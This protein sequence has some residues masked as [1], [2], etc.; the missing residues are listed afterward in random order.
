MDDDM[1]TNMTNAAAATAEEKAIMNDI[2]N[3]IDICVSNNLHYDI[4]LVCYKCLKDKHR[5]VSKTSSSSSS[6]DTN[7]NTW[8]YLT[9]AVWTTD[10]NNKQ[11]IYSIRTIVCIAFTK[12][13]LYWED[14][15]ENEKYPDT[16][17]IASKL[18]QISSKL[19]DN[20]YI[21]VLIKECKQFFMI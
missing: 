3:H 18:L 11:L 15:R 10:V 16:S 12:R 4:A 14:E 1:D 7:N 8:E 19:K 5:Y 20:K 2:N 6:S 17:V 9:N 21:L 13:S